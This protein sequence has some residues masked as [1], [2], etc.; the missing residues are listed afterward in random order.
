MLDYNEMVAS[1]VILVNAKRK[2]YRMLLV[3]AELPLLCKLKKL[4]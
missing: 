3:C 2:L 1:M 4:N